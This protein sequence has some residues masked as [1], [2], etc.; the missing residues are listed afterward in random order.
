MTQLTEHFSLAELTASDTAA[1]EGI[2]NTPSDEITSNL[3]G[4]A[5]GLEKVRA[6][7]GTPMHINSG[8]R[9]AALNAAVHGVA[10]SAHE[11][12]FAADFTSPDFGEPLAIVQHLQQTDLAFDQIIQEGTWVHISFDPQMRH[13]VLTAH[14]NNGVATYTKGV[15]ATIDEDSHGL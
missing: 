6:I 2:D 13:Q 7:L 11:E 8:Y 14:F 9:C 1:Q 12:G 10:H 5:E 15:P 3:Q 4:V